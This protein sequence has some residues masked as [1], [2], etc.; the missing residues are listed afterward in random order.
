MEDGQYACVQANDAEE[1]SDESLVIAVPAGT[2][3]W[4]S[5]CQKPTS[6][7][8]SWACL[9]RE[10]IYANANA[11]NEKVKQ[12]FFHGAQVSDPKGVFNAGLSGNKWRAIDIRK[13]DEIDEEALK[14]LLRE[15]IE[16]NR[17]DSVPKSKGSRMV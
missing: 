16:Y 10:G 8:S 9:D 1:P 17:K 13:G 14:G 5:S 6:Q 15:A 2:L 7:V 3:R 12:T 11:F 4:R